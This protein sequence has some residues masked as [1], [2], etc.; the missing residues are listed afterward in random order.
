MNN[1]EVIRIWS[2]NQKLG[3]VLPC[4]R[5]GKWK[6]KPELHTNALSRR[7]DIYVC[8][9]CGTLEALCD[10]QKVAD[11]YDLWYVSKVFGNSYVI[12]DFDDTTKQYKLKLKVERNINVIV[13]CEDIDDIMCGALEG[14]INYWCRKAEVVGEYLGEYGSEQISRGGTLKLYNAEED[15]VY[16]LTLAKFMCGL[17]LAVEMGFDGQYGWLNDDGTLDCCRIDAG[18]ADAIIQLAIFGEVIYG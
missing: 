16:E 1:K 10:M 12:Y 4:P 5:C 3:A 13:T 7:A 15:E 6:M 17:M 2:E 14:G 8:D 11:G 9:C 18:E